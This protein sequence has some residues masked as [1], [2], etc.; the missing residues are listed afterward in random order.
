MNRRVRNEITSENSPMVLSPA[1]ALSLAP[2]TSIRD[3]HVTRERLNL[4]AG[5]ALAPAEA[6]AAV[7]GGR[8]SLVRP[9]S[10]AA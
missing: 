7:L 2:I 10:T 5:A 1:R 3:L 4:G 8:T 9:P 6:Y